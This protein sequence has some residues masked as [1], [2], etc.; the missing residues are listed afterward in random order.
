MV[1]ALLPGLIV[2]AFAMAPLWLFHFSP[3]AMVLACLVG[4][5]IGFV[6]VFAVAAFL[7][8]LLFHD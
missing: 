5:G 4:A 6:V 8:A 2:A 7:L 3:P 1:L